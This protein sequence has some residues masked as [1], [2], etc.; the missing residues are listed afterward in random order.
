[1]AGTLS[2]G[3][4]SLILKLDTPYDTIRTSD[5]RD[6]LIKVKVWCSTTAGF[7]P[8]D[9]NKVF[10]G[11]SLSIII[12]NLTAGT[13]YYV[14]YAFISEIDESQITYSSEL[15]ATPVTTD[16]AMVNI[17]ATA[18]AFIEQ[19][20]SST[21][22]PANIVLT[23]T[24]VSIAGTITYQWKVDGVTQSET[25][26]T[27][28]LGSF[29]GNAKTVSVTVISGS[30]EASDEM[31]IFSL[32]EGDDAIS[33]GLVNQNQTISCNSDGVPIAGQLPFTTTFYAVRG[34]EILNGTASVAFSLVSSEGITVTINSS[35]G[36]V[37]VSNLT[38]LDAYA[39][40]RATVGTT[41]LESRLTLN[42]S[43][44]GYTPVKNVDYFDGVNGTSIKVQYSD[45]NISW[46]DSPLAGDLYIR[47][48][49]KAGTATDYTWAAGVKFVPEK[50]VEY[51]DGDPGISSYIHI[52]YSNDN[53]ITFTASNGETAGDYIGTYTDTTVADSTSTSSYTWAKIKG[54]PGYTPVKG[55]DYFDGVSGTSVKVQYSANNSS[56]HDAPLAGDL[57]IRTGT[58]AGNAADYTWAAGVKFVPEKGVEYDDGDPGISSYLHIKYSNDN[59]STFTANNGETPGDYLG[60]YTDST[61]SDSSSTSAYTWVKIKGEQGIQGIKGDKGDT[62]SGTSGASNHRAYIATANSTTAPSWTAGTTTQNGAAPAGWSLA[63]VTLSIG[64]AQWQIDGTTPAGSTTTTWATPYP[65]Y[66]KVDT[67]EAVTTNTGN[68]T[69]TG[70]IKVG[71]TASITN[72]ILISPD[73]ISIY[74]AG[75]LRVRL[76]SI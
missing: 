38:S 73:N 34:A 66:F 47:T 67:L 64:Q 74:N 7:T 76:G 44:N 40:F 56:W 48:G 43:L 13:A 52:K 49:T 27:F 58:K 22:L 33:A 3:V 39:L 1:M 25:S 26:N 2:A 21:I 15:T 68:L 57:Y 53:G 69:V 29:S 35:T 11:L 54:E 5:I 8:S 50:G 37:N 75:Q 32:R 46:H 17:T 16:A 31:S 42:K 28:T 41:Q 12:P 61:A 20:N 4:N 72:G 51:E 60:S 59:G 6:D 62:G 36:V 63:P 9:A 55:V 24:P 23:A 18:M 19:K 14:K 71:S 65:S 10:D 70:T 30:F 45:N